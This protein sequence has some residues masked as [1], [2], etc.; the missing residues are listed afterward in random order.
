MM[1]LFLNC[2][3]GIQTATCAII[4]NCIGTN[5]VPLAKRFFSMIT[6]IA[7]SLIV[8]ISLAIIYTRQAVIEF[9]TDDEE[10]Q[11]ICMT[12]FLVVAVNFLFDGLQAYFQGPIRA[13]GL[14]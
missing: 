4:G 6:K 3:L 10:V 14:Q 1:A 9:Y 11:E 7:V 5:N 13:M 12:V 8:T 2:P